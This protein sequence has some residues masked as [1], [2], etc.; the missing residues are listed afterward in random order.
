VRLTDFQ[1]ERVDRRKRSRYLESIGRWR[2]EVGAGSF[3][4]RSGG[5]RSEKTR[6]SHLYWVQHQALSL[7]NPTTKPRLGLRL[8]RGSRR[9]GKWKN[10]KKEMVVVGGVWSYFNSKIESVFNR[11][12]RKFLAEFLM[13]DVLSSLFYFLCISLSLSKKANYQRVSCV[14]VR[15]GTLFLV[16]A[17]LFSWFYIRLVK[18]QKKWVKGF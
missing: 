3:N 14:N 18:W 10:Q 8:L 4:K 17:L 12:R 9:R 13:R 2:R 16:W 11:K 1:K 5:G 15:A 6:E 7:K